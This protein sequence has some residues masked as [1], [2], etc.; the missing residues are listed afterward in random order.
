MQPT[1]LSA[2]TL[3]GDKVRNPQG[4][5]LGHLEEIV[6]DLDGGR[7]SYAVLASGGFLGLGDKFFAIPWDMLTVDTDNH[8]LIL[9]V[10][11]ETLENAP[12]FDKDNWP[13]AHDRSWMV[14]V[15]RYY[16]REPYWDDTLDEPA[17]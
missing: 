9:D 1:S 5:D 4:D 15:Y 12:G 3:K 7:V 10:P 17:L 11:K 13:D 6:I 8:E 16:G 14:D 2:S